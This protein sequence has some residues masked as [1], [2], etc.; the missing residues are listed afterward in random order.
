MMLI[1]LFFKWFVF[2]YVSGS[3][4]LG[5]VDILPDN[6]D[7][8]MANKKNEVV[9]K[10]SSIPNRFLGFVPISGNFFKKTTN[11]KNEQVPKDPIIKKEIPEEE[12]MCVICFF[13][14]S[15]TIVEPCLHGGMCK[16]CA[17][18]VLKKMG[19]CMFCRKKIEKIYIIK[20]KDSKIEVTGEITK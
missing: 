5:Q 2:F 9:V 3:Q 4:G 16:S 8:Q 10:T 20:I 11:I 19:T 18:D 13:H 17:K 7:R 6:R 12:K 14:E 15:E 1:S